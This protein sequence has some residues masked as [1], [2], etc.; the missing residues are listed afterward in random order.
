MPLKSRPSTLHLFF[1]RLLEN[2]ES[3]AVINKQGQVLHLRY[4]TLADIGTLGAT[5]Q[6]ILKYFPVKPKELVLLNDP[7]SGGS[8]LSTMSLLTGI[9]EDLFLIVRTGFRPHLTHAS[10]VDDE[11]L[12]VPPTPLGSLTDLN[13]NI[14]IAM[15]EHPL[16]P[17]N[18]ADRL[19]EV[20]VRM[21]SVVDKVQGFMKT[22]PGFLSMPALE[23]Y[24]E[25]TRKKILS[26]ISEEAFGE[27]EFEAEL[28]SGETLKL[29]LELN[30]YGLSLNFSGTSPSK[31][32]CL[33][34]SATFGACLGALSAFLQRTQKSL[35]MNSGFFSVLQVESPVG[36]LLN[37]KFPSPTFL[38]MT[39]GAALVARTVLKGLMKISHGKEASDSASLPLMIHLEWTPQLRFFESI[40]GGTG[41]SGQQAGS[42]ALPFWVRN[43]L[44]TSVEEIERRFP[45]LVKQF[46]LRPGSGGKGQQRGGHGMIREYEILK[47]AELSW[48]MET[49]KD[50][51]RGLKGAQ[52]GE[53]AEIFFIRKGEKTFIKEC[54]GR[55]SLK[56][57]DRLFVNSGG[58]GGFGKA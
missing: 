28:R 29:Q 57:G 14:L 6:T 43:Q 8:V 33:T 17:E 47:D 42:D 15:S 56:A 49:L 16:A 39:E 52:D 20:S 22:N 13:E 5:A 35:P 2:F 45:M 50:P 30:S 3:G 26:L 18:F 40:A 7:Y 32:L 38:G 36:S 48:L 4:E 53:S 1:E 51:S 25:D 46:G 37:A 41:A 31:R 11:G 12:R 54:F 21:A 58:G 9:S 55:M 19:R 23:S 10:K 34:D 44:E 27:A 24:L